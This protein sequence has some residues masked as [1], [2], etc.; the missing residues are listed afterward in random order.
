MS[1]LPCLADERPSYHKLQNVVKG[2]LSLDLPDDKRFKPEDFKY[3][4]SDDDYIGRGGFA[5]VY[6]AVIHQEG[7]DVMV[8]FKKPCFRGSR[9][10]KEY[11]DCASPP[12]RHCCS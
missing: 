8:A 7:Q 10:T 3:D 5:D 11:A 4:D 12:A 9:F 1:T 6:K 2:S